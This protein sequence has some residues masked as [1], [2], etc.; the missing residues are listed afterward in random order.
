M[1]VPHVD[2]A[3]AAGSARR[4]ARPAVLFNWDACVTSAWLIS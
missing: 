3:T 1:Q 2:G 4:Y